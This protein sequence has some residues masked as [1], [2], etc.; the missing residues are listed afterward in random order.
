MSSVVGFYS[1]DYSDQHRKWW[2]EATE[3][4]TAGIP[5]SLPAANIYKTAV[6]YHR[7]G[8][9]HGNVIPNC[10][11]CVLRAEKIADDT[12]TETGA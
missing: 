3:A 5:S 10:P 6:E 1:P 4:Y 2:E 12:R 7:W 9:H 8:K 11:A